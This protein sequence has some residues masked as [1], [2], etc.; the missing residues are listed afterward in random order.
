MRVIFFSFGILEYGGGLE[1]YLIATAP[2][3]I[4]GRYVDEA[5]II[6]A[7]PR[8]NEALQHLLTLYY[9]RK[10]STSTIYRE[11]A[12][13]IKIRLG[14][15][16]YLQA[17]SLRDLRERLQKY[18]VV[19]TKNEIIELAI[20]KLIGYKN[21]PP[22]VVGAHTPVYFT[23][24]PSVSAKL[25]NLIYGGF[26]YRYLLKG[27]AYIKCN[28]QEDMAF[29]QKK[30]KYKN[31]VVIHHGFDITEG[32]VRRNQTDS[33]N[34]LFAGRLSEA[35]GVDTLETII[36]TLS[37][38]ERFEAYRFRIAGSGDENLESIAESLARNYPN[39]EYL[40]H[41]PVADMRTL[42]E[43][44][45]ISLIPSRYETLNKIA[46]ETGLAS[47]IAIASDI[48]G[49]REVIENEKTGFLVSPEPKEFA[50]KIIALDTLRKTNRAKFN[51]IGQAAREKISREFNKNRS[52]IEL[53][54]LLEKARANR[55]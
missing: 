49:P 17:D 9:F 8:L 45:D 25:H 14:A 6:T 36:Q 22:V 12:K 52:Y 55:R 54:E 10:H 44:A 50:E 28:N 51:S 23:N 24:A 30:L 43:W 38:H 53:S 41:V 26:I 1:N 35:K 39:V 4:R 40:G 16:K 18:D 37:K 47:K 5:S 7:T 32:S 27:S 31:A 3:L 46:V 21:L 19:Y 48:S 13:D 33:L 20:L 2:D 15:V 11:S 34:I 29:V 42:Y